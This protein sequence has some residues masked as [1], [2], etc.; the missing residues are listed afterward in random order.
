MRPRQ[1]RGQV[2]PGWSARMSTGPSSR[3]N[4]NGLSG[5][6]RVDC[7]GDAEP[8]RA[9]QV[10]LH[11]VFRREFALRRQ[12]KTEPGVHEIDGEYWCRWRDCQQPI[13]RIVP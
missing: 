12:N 2:R 10:K 11:I 3:D 8:G 6:D 9:L 1:G 5:D 7:A 13:P 4:P